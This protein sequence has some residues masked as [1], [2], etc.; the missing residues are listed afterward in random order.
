MADGSLKFDTKINTEGFEKD[1]SDLFKAVKKWMQ[2]TDELSFSVQN[3][4]NRASNAASDVTKKVGDITDSAKEAERA[5]ADLKRQMDQIQVHHTEDAESALPDSERRVPVENPALYGYDKGAL[6]FIEQY[7]NNAQKAETHV[8]EFKQSIT[9]LETEVKGLEKQGL[10]FGDD[11]YDEAYLKLQKIKRALAD[12]KKELVSPTPDAMMFPA[13][14]LEGEVE[15]LNRK[16]QVL[17]AQ[18]KTFGD[19]LYDSTYQALN[20]A[21]TKLK[22]YKKN[23]TSPVPEPLPNL[24]EEAEVSNQ[25]IAELNQRLQ[26]LQARQKELKTA[27]VG[28]GYQEY[29]DNAREIASITAR[30]KEYQSEMMHAKTETQQY[31]GLTDSIKLQLTR[32]LD[33]FGQIGSSA[34]EA[35][36]TAPLKAFQGGVRGVEFV[37]KTAL[38]GAEKLAHG[39]KN[40]GFWGAKKAADAAKKS[41]LALIKALL[42][43]WKSAKKSQKGF[44]M[45]SMLGKSLA[46]SMVF[47]ALSGITNALKEGIQY[48]AQYS[49]SFNSLMTSLISS[50][51]QLK[52][53]FAPAFSPVSSI[54][55]PVLDALIQK[56]IQTMN[57]VGQFLAA[58]TGKGT[59]TKAVKVNQD[60]AA[61]LKKTG[62]AAKQAGADVKKAL[63]PFDD[64]V[65]IQQQSTESSGGSGTEIDPSQMFT[66]ESIDSEISDFA[67]K[68][69]E[70]FEAGDWEGIGQLI[71][72][73]INEAVLSFT[74]Y[75]SWDNVGVRVI[76]FMAAF[77]GIFNS[78]ASTVDWYSMGIMLGTGAD[79]L[80]N[81][82][83]LL[84]TLLNWQLLGSAVALGLNGMV[85]TVDW[86]LFGATL[87]AY[88]QARIAALY[89]FVS[90][91]NW[92]A[93]GQAISNALNGMVNQINW[94]MLGLVFANGFSGALGVL[95][96]FAL[97]FD[98][99]DFGASLALSLSTFFQNFDWIGSG[100]A[101]SAFGL[102]L[103]NAFVTFIK[104]TDWSALGTGVA[105]AALS[106]DWWNILL[107][108][109]DI[110]LQILKAVV[111]AAFPLL[112]EIAG[113]LWDGF[114]QGIKAFFN[115]PGAFIKKNIV[116][117]F[118]KYFREYF[119]IHSP[120][121]VMA[122]MG[123][124]LWA[125]FCE[126]IK[127]FFSDPAEFVR[128]NITDPFIKSIKNLLG[129]HSPSVVMNEIGGYTVEGFNRGVENGQSSTQG[130]VQ[131]W[132]SGIA[133]WFSSRLGI[134][135][136]DSAE[137]R[138][139]AE[140]TI[141]GFNVFVNK[142][143]KKSQSIMELWADSIR[144][145]FVGTDETQGVNEF[146]WIKFADSIILAFKSRIEERHAETQSSMESWAK[147][148][149]EWFWGDANPL[150][151]GGMYAAF[152]NMAKRI[153]EGFANGISDFAYLAKAAIRK[154]A[155]EA[156]EEAEEE[157][158]INS[159][160]KE[161]YTIAEYVVKGFNEGIS[162]M[163]R[164]SENAVQTW[165][166]RILDVFDGAEV[167]LPLGISV[168]N[169]AS[170]LPK[171]ASGSIV[172]PKAGM[173]SS[174][175]R[176]SA[177]YNQE[178][179]FSSLVSRIE[180]L[181]GRMQE[182][183]ERPTQIVLQLTGNL[184]SLARV[185]KPELDR[186][187]SRKGVSLVITGG[188]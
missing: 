42:G 63:A 48:F 136:G 130:I 145:W 122:E 70:M 98:W 124:Y 153:N 168:P 37:L 172:P 38:S 59:F 132:A 72:Q 12:Y 85:E 128:N 120:S 14:S 45:L 41:V 58:L 167:N 27:G 53:S 32:L 107:S 123:Q 113:Y 131:S 67:N 159:P 92:P 50:L 150:G 55:I 146:S 94:A 74:D 49:G 73:E 185:L 163:A 182:N 121:T 126:G 82:L 91:A 186:E 76:A 170:Y 183:G 81:T 162:D 175:M 100:T 35:F 52:N 30:L 2:A 105:D 9:E 176:N 110:F 164:S 1:L 10:Y 103:L 86:N 26:E 68:I 61:S 116:D 161:F 15:H 144:K 114:C 178:E 155:Q 43:I 169:A 4:F 23:L 34:E 97:T 101:V 60:Y 147:S 13:D 8:N 108:V 133:S 75:I 57:V 19:P 142:N 11:Q 93:I 54:V 127:A 46:F 71:G 22:E 99:A 135:S 138:K 69:R 24:K 148:I 84:L 36:E 64:L 65:Q 184:A 5:A 112:A 151:T 83:Y 181:I 119:G 87:G 177:G 80:I 62:G 106:V 140:S 21:Q 90:T 102:G 188:A 143:Y 149:R 158:D 17:S 180:E 3:S 173:M 160:S 115:D 29:E 154:W 20:K 78:L 179:E 44:S 89:G 117:P 16:L 104:E 157:F 156:M 31:V 152:Y 51:T 139:W 7:G 28:L 111:L 6:E 56:L 134:N 137:S 47:R 125:G 18:G 77:T 33:F 88:F 129:I 171:I 165:L 39:M 187:A 141:T 109:I 174:G 118:L 95:S 79:T 40:V 96:Y 66:E 166:E 25:E